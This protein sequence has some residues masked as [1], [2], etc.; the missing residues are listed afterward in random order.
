MEIRTLKGKMS[1]LNVRTL[2]EAK[3]ILERYL[4]VT[5]PFEHFSAAFVQYPDDPC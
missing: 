3:G 2:F 5:A 4:P 1:L